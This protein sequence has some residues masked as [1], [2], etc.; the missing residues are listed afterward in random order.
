MRAATAAT[1]PRRDGGHH[2]NVPARRYATV[3]TSASRSSAYVGGR[4]ASA[5]AAEN[6]GVPRT[7]GVSFIFETSSFCFFVRHAERFVEVSR[8]RRRVFVPA[9]FTRRALTT[10][11]IDGRVVD[12]ME[13]RPERGEAE[14]HE[15]QR[16][17]RADAPRG[18]PSSRLS[19]FTSRCTTPARC[20]AASRAS[21]WSAIMS[22]VKRL[23]GP[24]ALTAQDISSSD[25][26][27][28]SI[29]STRLSRP[30]TRCLP[31]WCTRGNPAG[32]A[33]FAT[34]ASIARSKERG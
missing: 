23:S 18:C 12:S 7:T 1:S 13:T 14:V 11:L 26:P 3:N 32:P 28:R 2:G 17:V 31:K 21:A 6:A 5:A 15:V 9:R 19:G 25:G 30:N 22:V 24:P 27:S 34:R 29:T 33:C 16:A 10:P 20:T 8:G 4:P